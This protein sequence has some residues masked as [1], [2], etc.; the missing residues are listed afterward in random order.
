MELGKLSYTLLDLNA[1]LPGDVADNE[2]SL[3]WRL[4]IMT[5]EEFYSHSDGEKLS[6]TQLAYLAYFNVLSPS[7]HNTVPQRFILEEC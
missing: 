6:E 3:P 7:S 5:P 1:T 2:T 4:K